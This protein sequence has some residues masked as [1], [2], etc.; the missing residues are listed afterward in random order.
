MNVYYNK[1]VVAVGNIRANREEASALFDLSTMRNWETRCRRGR[2][3]L[4]VGNSHKSCKAG[5]LS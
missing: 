5:C 3:R 4:R 1:C 2:L